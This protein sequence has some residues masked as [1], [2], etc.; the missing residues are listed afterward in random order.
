MCTFVYLL[1]L[2]SA[3]EFVQPCVFSRLVFAEACIC[4]STPPPQAFVMN[5]TFA[6]HLYLLLLILFI[7]PLYAALKSKK[8]QNFSL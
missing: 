8:T 6:F 1:C 3:Q 2:L 4:L 7:W 5:L